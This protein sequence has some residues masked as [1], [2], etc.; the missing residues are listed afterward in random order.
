MTRHVT[1]SVLQIPARLPVLKGNYCFY[2]QATP[3]ARPRRRCCNITDLPVF[4]SALP[5]PLSPTFPRPGESSPND[6]TSWFIADR[7]GLI[8]DFQ[9]V[10]TFTSKPCTST[11]HLYRTYMCDKVESMRARDSFDKSLRRSL[12]F[13]LIN[14]R[15]AIRLG[16]L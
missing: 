9:A 4:P 2:S 15:S 8:M 16:V 10:L 6:V 11:T 3:A 5:H 1:E 12:L 13:S 7:R 14:V